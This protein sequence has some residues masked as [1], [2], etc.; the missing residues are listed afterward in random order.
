MAEQEIQ[1]KQPI[2]S[3]EEKKFNRQ[4][5]FFIM[6]YMW[7][8]ICGRHPEDTI[9]KAFHTSRERYTRIINTGVVR[10]GKGELDSLS[11]ITGLRKEIF[12]GEVRFNC[13]YGVKKKD[14]EK[15][16]GIETSEITDEEWKTLIQWRKERTGAKGEKSPQDEIYKRLRKVK[17]SDVENWDFYRLCYFLKE[18]TPAPPKVTK[19]Q[20]RDMVQSVSGLSFSILDKCEV[21]QLRG[22]QKLL[23][24][25]NRLVTGIITY[26]EAKAGEKKEK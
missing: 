4:V 20:F 8:V 17:Q 1:T 10:Y 26:K 21:A 25:K 24:E 12:L 18:R 11:Q 14:A 9:Y 19:E 6:R 13:P 23:Q 15:Q 22:L 5:N 7:Q 16:Q 3:D 2:L